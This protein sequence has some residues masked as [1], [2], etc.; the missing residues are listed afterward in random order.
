MV[1]HFYFFNGGIWEYTLIIM[2]ILTLIAAILIIFLPETVVQ[3]LPLVFNL[4]HSPR[5]GRNKN[6]EKRSKYFLF[7]QNELG[8]R[9]YCLLV[10]NYTILHYAQSMSTL[11]IIHSNTVHFNGHSFTLR[12]RHLYLQMYIFS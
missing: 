9:V 12:C 10:F 4:Y 7:F 6:F 1:L 5:K 2:E 8:K 11:I 3:K